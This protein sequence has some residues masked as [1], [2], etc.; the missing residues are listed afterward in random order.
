MSNNYPS[1]WDT[2]VTLY[3]KFESSTGEVTW[4]R[5]VLEGCFWKYV[6]DYVRTDNATEMIKVL[7]CRVRKNSD[8]LEPE[9]WCETDDKDSHFTFSDGD[10]L[11]KG[12]VDDVLDEYTKGQRSSDLLKKYKNRCAEI[13]E[14]S[15]N[16]GVDRVNEHY[17]VRGL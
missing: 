14:Y 8:F 1:W 10:I 3:N 15:G 11:I 17:L 12:E 7:L 5:T 6:T 13:K 2:T 4:Y 9:E 16:V